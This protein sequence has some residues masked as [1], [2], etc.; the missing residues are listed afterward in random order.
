M[1]L[2]RWVVEDW[3]GGVSLRK[4]FLDEDEADAECW[5]YFEETRKQQETL[6][7]G[8]WRAATKAKRKR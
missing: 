2:L 3:F 1:D 7:L 8:G 6:G 4:V 5:W